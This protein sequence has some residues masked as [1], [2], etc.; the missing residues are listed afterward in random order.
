MKRKSRGAIHGARGFDESNPY[1]NTPW[2]QGNSRALLSLTLCLTFTLVLGILFLLPP[3]SHGGDR[4]QSSD[5]RDPF[6]PLIPEEL[7]EVKIPEFSG[8]EIT[9]QAILVMQNQRG[10]IINNHFLLEGDMIP[11]TSVRIVHIEKER[12]VVNYRL[13]NYQVRIWNFFPIIKSPSIPLLQRGKEG[14]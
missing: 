4:I 5:R 6:I 3:S 9:L 8:S 2:E 14:D 12:V 7:T 11:N 10:V 13:N 1:R